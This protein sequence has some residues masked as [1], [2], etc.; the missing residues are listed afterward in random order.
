MHNGKYFPNNNIQSSSGSLAAFSS[1]NKKDNK[2]TQ[3][4]IP[5]YLTVLLI[6]LEKHLMPSVLVPDPYGIALCM[7]Y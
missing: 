7:I 4:L 2:L 6:L 5:Q 1:T 3:E